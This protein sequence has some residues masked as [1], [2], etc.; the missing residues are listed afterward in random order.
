MGRPRKDG[1]PPE[2]WGQAENGGEAPAAAENKDAEGQ[3]VNAGDDFS[4]VSP[5]EN[6][7]S[8]VTPDAG[9]PPQPGEN[10]DGGSGQGSGNNP[11]AAPS[12]EKVRVRHSGLANRAVIAG[13]AVI[14]FD[15]EGC[16]ELD[17]GLAEYLLGI[18]GYEEA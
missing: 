9:N 2:T 6:G 13:D 14:G 5:Q 11:P 10:K 12:T 7:Q 1:T 16:A 4:D 18:P 15:A 3:A 17:A 8:T